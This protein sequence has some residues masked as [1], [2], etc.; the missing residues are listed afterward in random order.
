MAMSLGKKAPSFMDP[1]GTFVYVWLRIAKSEDI[2]A[3]LSDSTADQ[4]V[5]ICDKQKWKVRPILL[6]F[7]SF[8]F[9][10]RKL[11][12]RLSYLHEL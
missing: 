2:I 4:L 9:I 10:Y 5:E 6:Q 8:N 3:A 7:G 11:E 1:D 12:I